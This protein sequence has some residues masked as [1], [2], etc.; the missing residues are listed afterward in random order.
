VTLLELVD[1]FEEAR[2]ESEMREEI[3]GKRKAARE[4]II[5]ERDHKVSRMMHKESL[6][7][8]IVDTWARILTH[9]GDPIPL[10]DLHK[11]GVEDYLTIFVASLFLA[12]HGRIRLWQNRFPF[13]TIDLRKLRE[14]ELMGE[15]AAARAVDSRGK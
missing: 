4:R 1:A 9:N 6:E 13:G 2:R 15:L 12:L 8:D 5:R 10:E 3:E 11:D 14:G 7:D